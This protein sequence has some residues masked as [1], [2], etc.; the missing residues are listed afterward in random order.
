MTMPLGHAVISRATLQLT[1]NTYT[2]LLVCKFGRFCLSWKTYLTPLP[3][4]LH[5]IIPKLSHGVR[6]S[7]G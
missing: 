6:P 3:L 4:L 2:H 5:I 1:D 7:S